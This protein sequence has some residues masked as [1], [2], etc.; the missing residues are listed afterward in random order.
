M[1]THSSLAWPNSLRKRES[2]GAPVVELCQWCAVICKLLYS[3]QHSTDTGGFKF[4]S[5]SSLSGKCVHSAGSS[6]MLG[7]ST[8]GVLL[9]FRGVGHVRLYI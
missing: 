6:G 8:T 2:V 3:S 9:D 1:Y 7:N 4:M 5:L